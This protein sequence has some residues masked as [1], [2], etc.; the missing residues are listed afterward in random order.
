MDKN[1]NSIK[2][3]IMTTILVGIVIFG[4]VFAFTFGMLDMKDVEVKENEVDIDELTQKQMVAA[5]MEIDYENKKMKLY[6]YEN[7]KMIDEEFLFNSSTNFIDADAKLMS[8]DELELGSLA[9]IIYTESSGIIAQVKTSSKT[10]E[11]TGLI[12]F[13]LDYANDLIITKPKEYKMIEDVVM[14]YKNEKVHYSELEEQVV[15]TLRGYKKKI[16][17]IE[18]EEY[19]GNIRLIYPQELDNA[20]VSIDSDKIVKISE[21]EDVYLKQGEHILVISKKGLDDIS[22]NVQVKEKD[23]TEVTIDDVS[24]RMGQLKIKS[25]IS[26][27]YMTVK[28]SDGNINKTYTDNLADS[29]TAEK[30]LSDVISLPEGSYVMTF[31]KDNYKTIT[32]Q[33]SV[34]EN[35]EKELNVTFVTEEGK[36]V[37]ESTDKVKL[38][39][40]TIP[41]DASIYINGDYKGTGKVTVRVPSGATAVTVSKNG[42]QTI[43][44]TLNINEDKEYTFTLSKTNIYETPEENTNNDETK[45]ESEVSKDVYNRN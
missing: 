39:I 34:V 23:I 25:N 38:V 33:I 9:E 45:N 5:I 18:I 11:E 26:N 29:T 15:V 43:E 36:A 10:W 24:Y 42:Y 31:S 35:T 3:M 12:E 27:Y 40:E 30:L 8:R 17:A 19:L 14:Y 16:Y 22:F 1:E 21:V 2:R 7:E 37:T 28:S 4:A 13:E 6:D 32:R 41:N 20:E 44:R